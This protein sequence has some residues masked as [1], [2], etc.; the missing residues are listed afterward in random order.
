VD[1][2][3]DHLLQQVEKDR[4]L[5]PYRGRIASVAGNDSRGGVSREDAVHGFAPESS[6]AAPVGPGQERDRFDILICTDVL[7]EGMNLQQCRNI[8]NYDLPWNPMRLVQ[9]HGRV[10]RIGSAHNEVYLRTFFPDQEL[11]RLLD[12]EMRV[13]T[14][15]ARAAASVGVE[16]SPIEGGAQRDQS[17]AE[18]REEIERL[19]TGDAEIFEIGGTAGAAQT[20]EEYRQ[21][22]RQALL[23][24][25][26]E[27]INLPWKAG[28]GMV[29]GNRRV[30]FICARVGERVY[31]R[32]V[33]YAGDGSH[34]EIVSELGTCLRMIECRPE[35]AREMPL[36]LNQTAY[37]A[38]ERARR[39]IFDAWSFETDS[40]NLQPRVPKLNRELAAYIRDNPPLTIEQGVERC[41][42]AIEAPCS[43]REQA[44]LRQV[45]EADYP[46]PTNRS[47]A[48]VQEVQRIG[49]EPFDAPEPLPPIDEDEV[50]LVCWLAIESA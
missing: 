31:L 50:W 40:A 19:A 10:D 22:L 49:L 29:R 23:R 9:R 6:R 4:R 26:E 32:F 18:T 35:T 1:W 44:L 20:G 21:E 47:E 15:L 2:I 27:I 11:N 17:F 34:D 43:L 36:D 33:P 46:A 45:F 30:H 12:L 8:I 42:E 13:K 7:A 25:E 39:Q 3:E 48:I 28:S 38:W 24:Q 41:L 37:T 5:A 14:K 16:A